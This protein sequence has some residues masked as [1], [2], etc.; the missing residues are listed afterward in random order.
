MS[1]NKDPN[2]KGS[3]SQVFGRKVT[4]RQFRDIAP[5]WDES[6]SYQDNMRINADIYD[7]PLWKSLNSGEKVD[8][9]LLRKMADEMDENA[10]E[11]DKLLETIRESG[12]DAG[13]SPLSIFNEEE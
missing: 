1:N 12:G 3:M 11:L 9:K 6:K 8:T 13:Y 2:I 10:R 7:T 4:T 5:V